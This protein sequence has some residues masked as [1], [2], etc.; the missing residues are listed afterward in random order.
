[1]Q[2]EENK[3]VSDNETRSNTFI[4]ISAMYLSTLYTDIRCYM[5]I[6]INLVKLMSMRIWV[7]HKCNEQGLYFYLQTLNSWDSHC[8]VCMTQFPL[9]V[10]RFLSG[11]CPCIS[12]FVLFET[13]VH[14][15]YLFEMIWAL[16]YRES[17]V[18]DIGTG[19]SRMSL[20]EDTAS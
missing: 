2:V 17:I 8:C 1:M 13:M 5:Y 20:V 3:S 14:L 18:A 10:V 19:S 6:Y 16:L 7:N 11:F 15:F 4:C 12:K 9:W